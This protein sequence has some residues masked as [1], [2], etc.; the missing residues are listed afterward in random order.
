MTRR[1]LDMKRY[2]W[3]LRR[4]RFNG[5]LTSEE[6]A[7][8]RAAVVSLCPY[9]RVGDRLWVKETWRVARQYNRTKPV[10]LPFERGLTTAYA[11]GGIKCRDAVGGPYVSHPESDLWNADW[12]GKV[13]PSLFMTRAASRLTLEITALRIER[14]TEITEA[15]AIA[16]GVEQRTLGTA[17]FWR[18]YAAD[19][20]GTPGIA[21]TA[22]ESFASLWSVINGEKS[23][24]A[25]PWVWVVSFKK[26]EG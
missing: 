23:W 19:E 10:N 18:G 4:P 12:L 8:D 9:G 16:E 14:L 13:R 6:H 5:E 1:L 20:E 21:L 2:G 17:K 15:D 25:N 11:A 22:R 7:A 24:N 3:P 26:V